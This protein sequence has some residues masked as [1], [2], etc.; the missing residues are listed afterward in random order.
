MYS[1]K[2]RAIKRRVAKKQKQNTEQKQIQD[3]DNH[4]KYPDTLDKAR[5]YKYNFWSNKPVSKFT[6]IEINSQ[7]LEEKISERKVYSSDEIKLPETM[8]WVQVDFDLDFN[9]LD[10]ISEFLNKYY[11][12]E[13]DFSPEFIKWYLRKNKIMICIMN[14]FDMICGI[15]G[16]TIES[17]TVYDKTEQFAEVKLLCAHPL[18]RKKKIAF[19][20]IDEMVRRL[21]KLGVK[22]GHFLTDKCVPTPR[23]LIRTFYRPINYLNLANNKFM[24]KGLEFGE[25]AETI[26]KKFMTNAKIPENIVIMEEKHLDSVLKLYNSYMEKFNIY[27][28]YDKNSLQDLLFNKFVK[29]YVILNSE[30]QVMDFLSYYELI[31]SHESNKIISGNLYLHTCNN[32]SLDTIIR[33]MIIIMEHNK[34]DLFNVTDIAGINDSLLSKE[35]D[36]SDNSD[37]DQVQNKEHVY[38]QKFIKGTKKLYLNFFN[39]RC[40]ELKPKQ[41]YL[42]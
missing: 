18:Y 11:S 38:E 21:I 29:S 42:F 10:N 30:L 19:T 4:V 13:I 32:I 37:N 27:H 28:N 5:K 14:N 17:L 36:L 40:P 15:I 7:R 6:D 33:N 3:Q 20:L 26:N 39:W 34:I 24:N 41:V 2:T 12:Q 35:Y 25:D 9:L 31:T 8:K 22:Q 16:A 1:N 23:T